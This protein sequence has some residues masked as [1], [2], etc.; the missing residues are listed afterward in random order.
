M[1]ETYLDVPSR[2]INSY[3]NSLGEVR[4]CVAIAGAFVCYY[5]GCIQSIQ[6]KYR[7]KKLLIGEIHIDNCKYN[8]P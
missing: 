7:Q 3:M 1:I 5:C 8:K 6:Y 4:R 2:F